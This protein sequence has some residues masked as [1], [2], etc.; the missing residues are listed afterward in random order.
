MSETPQHQ[1]PAESVEEHG[2][3]VDPAETLPELQLSGLR[4]R[5]FIA[6]LERHLGDPVDF[7]PDENFDFEPI[8]I[9]LD[10]AVELVEHRA[11]ELAAF[12]YDRSRVL[13]FAVAL[14]A[15]VGISALVV[16]LVMPAT[17]LFAWAVA[18]IELVLVVKLSRRSR[19]YAIECLELRRLAERYRPDLSACSTTAELRTLANR[20]RK[21]MSGLWISP[22]EPSD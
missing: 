16:A 13:R 2:E 6:D 9:R 11:E 7:P 12:A 3:T 8:K 20:M 10:R 21:E 22:P 14:S 15:V 1:N 18:L 17:R 19:G 4:Q 5:L